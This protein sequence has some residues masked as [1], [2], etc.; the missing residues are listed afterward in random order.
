MV[1]KITIK[2]P[3]NPKPSL[4]GYQNLAFPL[5]IVSTE[6]EYKPWYYS[7]FIHIC[8]PSNFLTNGKGGFNFFNQYFFMDYPQ[9]FP[10]LKSHFVK[11]EL[12]S[13][14]YKGG[15]LQFIK[16]NLRRNRYVMTWVDEYDISS[17]IRYQK[18]HLYHDIL[19]YGY[20]D[21]SFSTL[22]FDKER[23]FSET[24]IPFTELESLETTFP[25]WDIKLL[26][27]ER[28][29]DF[30]YEFDLELVVQSLREYVLSSNPMR[31]FRMFRNESEDYIYGFAAYD[32]LI[33]YIKSDIDP[34]TGFDIR[35]F[36]VLWE[37][38]IC[39]SQRIDY[40]I[41][42]GYMSSSKDFVVEWK[43]VEETFSKLR[44]MMLKYSF[45]GNKGLLSGGIDLL[46]RTMQ[47]EKSLLN[48][49]IEIL[50]RK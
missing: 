8:C 5:A 39:M 15:V 12:I 40:M 21:H 36:H 2:L 38:K 1:I 22:G 30:K 7:N 26:I 4:I 6:E 17:R 33:E 34:Q 13:E 27:M 41:S 50:G 42:E 29:D 20:D 23:K 31:H 3:I 37:H 18:K 14:M 45:T 46:Q 32:C 24:R 35:P 9:G 28:R 10:H 19:F 16:D 47:V 49:L 25:N 48:Q 11:R 43:T 44:N